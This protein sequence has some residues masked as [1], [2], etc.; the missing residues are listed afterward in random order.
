MAF[1]L[2]EKDLTLLLRSSVQKPERFGK[3]HL[4]WDFCSND[5]EHASKFLHIQDKQVTHF[6][7]QLNKKRQNKYRRNEE[8]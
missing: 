3:E 2:R 6:P 1:F 4:P 7:S 5:T 8:R